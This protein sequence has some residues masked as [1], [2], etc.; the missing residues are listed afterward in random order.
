MARRLFSKSNNL[1]QAATLLHYLND[2]PA[3]K[4]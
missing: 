3:K 4:Y 1:L 2:I